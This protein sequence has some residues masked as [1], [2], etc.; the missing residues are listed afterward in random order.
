MV[1]LLSENCACQNTTSS[2][3]LFTFSLVGRAWAAATTEGLLIY[4]LDGGV[5]FDP[6]DLSVE[7]TPE[8]IGNAFR[9]KRFSSALVMSFRLNEHDL[10]VKALEAVPIDDG[11]FS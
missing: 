9:E 7:V 8:G 6:F 4:T 10:I 5:V 2:L 11:G 1:T 3:V